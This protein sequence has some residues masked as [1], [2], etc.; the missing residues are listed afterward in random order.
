MS[1]IPLPSTATLKRV[2]LLIPT[3][4]RPFASAFGW[5]ANRLDPLD[6]LE[7]AEVVPVGKEDEIEREHEEEERLR[8]RELKQRREKELVETS[9]MVVPILPH[10]IT[11]PRASR[12]PPAPVLPKRPERKAKAKLRPPKPPKFS[13]M[14]QTKPAQP[15]PEPRSQESEQDGLWIGD[16]EPEHMIVPRAPSRI[17][18]TFELT[19]SEFLIP[20]KI[21]ILPRSQPRVAREMK[22]AM[23]C[24]F[25]NVWPTYEDDAGRVDESGVFVSRGLEE[26][27][28]FV[29]DEGELGDEER[30][31]RQRI[32]REW[33]AKKER[34]T[35]GRPRVKGGFGYESVVERERLKGSGWGFTPTLEGVVE[36][37]S[38]QDCKEDERKLSTASMRPMRMFR[39]DSVA[40]SSKK[41]MT[42][43]RDF[44]QDSVAESRTSTIEKEARD[45]RDPSEGKSSAVGKEQKSGESIELPENDATARAMRIWAARDLRQQKTS[46][47][48]KARGGNESGEIKEKTR[49]SKHSQS[50][51]KDKDKSNTGSSR[52]PPARVTY[53]PWERTAMQR[54]TP[55]MSWHLLRNHEKTNEH[56]SQGTIH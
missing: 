11:P 42:A 6:S 17:H 51:S 53:R 5:L 29:R 9:R 23:E 45:T 55:T 28:I 20:N 13:E 16:Q 39:G 37:K 14:P 7:N 19:G 40:E 54:T 47:E 10:E 27:E 25:F 8:E 34:S 48:G 4:L 38:A 31:R 49:T 30:E 32:E 35:E 21:K 33:M 56:G 36:K 41:S 52:S 15:Q 22:E 24:E 44:L 12:R 2:A 46:T 50:R 43:T 18:S 1:Q 3:P 26:S